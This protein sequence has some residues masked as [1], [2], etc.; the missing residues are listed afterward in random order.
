MG[1]NNAMGNDMNNNQALSAFNASDSGSGTSE[2]LLLEIKELTRKQVRWQRVSAAFMLGIL[3][4]VLVVV[5]ILLPRVLL[6][7]D[8]VDKATAQVS[9]SIT[10]VMKTVDQVDGAVAE[11]QTASENLNG[12][13]EENSEKITDA[14][15][16]LS[17]V[18]Y[19]GLNKAIKDLQ[20]AVGPVA[21]FFN[22]FR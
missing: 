1:D 3:T 15:T 22:K 9:E 12:L 19:E 7:L 2:Q 20:N 13:V 10:E 6:T 14:V 4:V 5:V 8:G 11:L 21:N 17:E 18:D 16:K